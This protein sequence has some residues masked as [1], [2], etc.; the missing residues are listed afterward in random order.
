MIGNAIAIIGIIFISVIFLIISILT[1]PPTN[2]IASGMAFFMGIGGYY[3]SYQY[4]YSLLGYA[5]LAVGIISI[6][7]TLGI[8]VK[9]LMV[10][11]NWG[12][13]VDEQLRKGQEYEYQE[14]P[15]P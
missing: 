10:E 9:D 7:Y 15:R 3:L 5:P 6:L 8:V 4:D 13:D 14:K 1:K 2:Y 11:T 12:N